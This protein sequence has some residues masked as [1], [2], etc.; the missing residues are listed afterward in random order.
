M[1]TEPTFGM[2]TVT[3]EAE[4][5]IPAVVRLA[6]DRGSPPAAM[7]DLLVRAFDEAYPTRDRTVQVARFVVAGRVGRLK[8]LSEEGGCVPPQVRRR[9][10][11]VTTPAKAQPGDSPEGRARKPADCHPRR[12]RRDPVS[13]VAICVKR[14]RP[15]R[16][17]CRLEGAFAEN[18]ILGNHAFRLLPAT[19]RQN[20]RTSARRVAGGKIDDVVAAAIA[21]RD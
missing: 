6:A 5:V 1:Q 16:S 17:C 18:R 9:C 12:S 8:L 21:A 14:R 10:I 19:S 13:C 4:A 20:G 7:A 3:A 15:R 11:W 2:S